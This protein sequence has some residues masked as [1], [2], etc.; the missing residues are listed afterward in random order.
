M[1]TATVDHLLQQE[2]ANHGLTSL[3]IGSLPAAERERYMLAIA[4]RYRMAYALQG[5]HAFA[6][7]QWQAA[8]HEAGHVTYY[9]ACG[10]DV[11]QVRIW[12]FV[13]SDPQIGRIWIGESNSFKEF[14][15]GPFTPPEH[16]LHEARSML[17]GAASEII[18]DAHDF[19]MASSADEHILSQMICGQVA[20]KVDRWSEE[21]VMR[22]WARQFEIVMNVLRDN[23]EA[24]LEIARRLMRR[25]KIVHPQLAR[26][27]AAV[28]VRER[29]KEDASYV[30]PTDMLDLCHRL[31]P[32]NAGLGG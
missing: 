6:S 31:A 29:L 10:L 27:L 17:A 5:W 13:H 15:I 24:T 22:L 16:D 28:N 7:T 23:R 8:L 26:Y 14:I 25:R 32:D 18:H 20:V 2:G 1:D 21:Y 12:P 19:R 9:A 4:E 3:L 11:R 30:P